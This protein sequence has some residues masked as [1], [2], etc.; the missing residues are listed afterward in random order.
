MKLNATYSLLMRRAFTIIFFASINVFV[1][2]YCYADGCTSFTQQSESINFGDVTVQPGAKIGDVIF[3][4]ISNPAGG[5]TT[6]CSGTIT[7]QDLLVYSSKLSSYGNNVYDTNISGVGIRVYDALTPGYI[8]KNPAAVYG[9][10]NVYPYV[11]YTNNGGLTFELIKTGP[12]VGG[13]FRTGLAVT[14]RFIKT[15]GTYS[16]TGLDI[17]VSGGSISDT[18]CNVG[19]KNITIPFG[20]LSADIFTGVGSTSSPQKFSLDM[21]CTPDR[22]LTMNLSGTQ[23]ADVSDNSVLALTGAGGD[24]VATGLGVQILLNEQPMKL[25]EPTAIATGS[26]D[27]SSVNFGARYYQTKNIVSAGEANATATLNITYY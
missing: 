26:G 7:F 22:S 19:S 20:T 9:F 14:Y 1:S 24:G 18:T 17:S 3:K 25:N 10:S 8:A 16:D 5:F 27:M 21:Q 6:G 12:I 13:K 2:T 11:V 15:D 23:S 4:G